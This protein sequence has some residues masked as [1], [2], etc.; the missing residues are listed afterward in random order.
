[1]TLIGSAAS[2]KR[3]FLATFA[4][5]TWF[6]L[7][8]VSQTAATGASSAAAKSSAVPRAH[9]QF[10]SERFPIRA[11]LYYQ[12]FWGVDSLVVRQV[13][14]GEMIRFSYRV[15]DP[16]KAKILNDKKYPPELI[17][18]QAG[19]KLTV[20]S[21]EKVGQLRQSVPPEAGKSYWM[22]FSNKGRFVKR[23]DHVEIVIGTFHATGLVVD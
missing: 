9:S 17:D 11:R 1:M 15:L 3:I 21:L 18:P 14:A 19:V 6:S 13:E 16:A 12:G 10:A 4:A 5:L 2:K 20:P 22:A 8:A 7:S 23:G